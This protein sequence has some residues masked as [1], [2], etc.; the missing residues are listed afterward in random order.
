MALTHYEMAEYVFFAPRTDFISA[1]REGIFSVVGY[2]SLQIIGVGMGRLIYEEMIDPTHMKMLKEG[3]PLS[4]IETVKIDPQKRTKQEKRFWYK[5]IL[6]EI[7]LCLAY[8]QSKEVFGSPSRRLC[9][10]PYCL[11][12]IGLKN[13]FVIITVFLDR[14]FVERPT[15]M[16]D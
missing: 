11:F 4:E 6:L 7:I 12:Q 14:V 1:N 8:V 10:L 5:M 16:V 9:N 15:N 13:S 3:K 2:F